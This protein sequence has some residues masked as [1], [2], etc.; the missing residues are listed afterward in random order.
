MKN[1]IDFEDFLSDKC[2]CHTNN[3]PSGFDNWLERLDVQELMD[4]GQ[5]FGEEC[6][7]KG[8]QEILKNIDIHIS[9][10]D[11]LNKLIKSNPMDLLGK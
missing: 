7:L 9:K 2:D 11:E 5:E 6:F 8:R 3:D 4:W 1:K 10:L